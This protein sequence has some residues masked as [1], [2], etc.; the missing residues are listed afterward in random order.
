MSGYG[1][2]RNDRS[3]GQGRG[4]ASESYSIYEFSLDRFEICYKL[5]SKQKIGQSKHSWES[6]LQAS[7]KAA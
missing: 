3:T 2:I 7:M 6:G 5:S 4:V 1:T